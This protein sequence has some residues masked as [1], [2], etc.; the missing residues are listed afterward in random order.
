MIKT[1]AI[2]VLSLLSRSF[3]Y[4]ER[5]PTT[6]N[7]T[8]TDFSSSNA[9]NKLNSVPCGSTGNTETIC[10]PRLGDIWRNG[11]W[12]PITWNAF[13]PAYV[14]CNS[15]DI[16]IYFVQN[17]QNILIK[18]ILDIRT[19]KG[20]IP[21]LVD[22]TW[23]L[24]FTA[25]TYNAITYIVSNG[26]DPENELSKHYSKYPQPIHSFVEQP[27]LNLPI[28]TTLNT[29]SSSNPIPP[30]SPT[31]TKFSYSDNTDNL[32]TNLQNRAVEPWVITAVVLACLAVI[33]ASI[34]ILWVIRQGRKRKLVNIERGNLNDSNNAPDSSNCTEKTH[35]DTQLSESSLNN[36]HSVNIKKLPSPFK[37]I[38]GLTVSRHKG[39]LKNQQ[40]VHAS[41][42]SS[43]SSTTTTTTTTA[44]AAAAA[45]AAVAVAVTPH[46]LNNGNT[47]KQQK[48]SQFLS[49]PILSMED[50]ERT[51]DDKRQRALR[52]VGHNS[53]IESVAS[54]DNASSRSE[55]PIS[56]SDA[57]LI[58]DT[59]R[60]RMRR[61]E[62]QQ[63]KQLNQE[64]ED[65]DERVEDDNEESKRRE[66]SDQLLKI[67]LEAEGASMKNV[68]KRAH[69]LDALY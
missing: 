60:Q 1:S 27:V 62:W 28:N 39:A 54:L 35:R 4:G 59:F 65:E 41:S 61:P 46:E 8:P 37:Y 42:S 6:T 31:L 16:Y 21:V 12:Y 52:N 66:L 19:S 26:V 25:Q 40:T 36:T 18:K 22:D 3:V 2:L 45:A 29:T 10:S 34:A 11:T 55:P 38:Y 49:T 48:V 68:G 30:S 7:E 58:A 51:S 9:I 67:E 13:H 20:T 23:R 63:Q 15:L 57:I 64:Q 56:S 24:D 43:S 33:G 69:L 50:E 32:Q 53:E 17:Y 14:S 5:A 47:I 44:A